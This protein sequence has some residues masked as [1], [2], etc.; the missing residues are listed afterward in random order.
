V[1]VGDGSV[2]LERLIDAARAAGLAGHKH[3]QR[4]V[5]V[6]EL[7]RTAAGKVKKRDLRRL[8]G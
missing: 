5:V 6:D 8:L 3:P 2:T 7:P 4:L 1:V